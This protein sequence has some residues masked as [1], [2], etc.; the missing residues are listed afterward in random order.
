MSC[1]FELIRKQQG[2]LE[3]LEFELFSSYPELFAG[4]F[5]RRDTQKPPKILRD[6]KSTFDLK[7]LRCCGQ[8]HADEVAYLPESS[9][10]FL[11]KCDGMVTNRSNEPLLIKHA[12]C[13]AAIFFDPK[14][15]SLACVHAGWRGQVKNIYRKT[16][17]TMKNS[18]RVNPKDLLVAI[19]PSLGPLHSEFIN[20]KTEWPQEYWQFQVR[21][22]YFDL[23]AISEAQLLKAG[24]LPH[25]IQ[26]AK[27]CTYSDPLDFYSYRREKSTG[28]SLTG[29]HVTIAYF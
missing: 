17:E 16:V 6:I 23:W 28:Q 2:D 18:L 3:W 20:Y 24:V 21:P 1:T 26:L 25:N 14:T 5:L 4:V 22:T 12:D 9:D 7:D 10:E 11:T 29:Q 13:Q 15:R 19:S 27:L 8:P